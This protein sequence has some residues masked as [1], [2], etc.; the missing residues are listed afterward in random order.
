[1]ERGKMIIERIPIKDIKTRP[2]NVKIHTIE[3]IEKIKASIREFGNNDPVAVDE[4]NEL[5]EG[6]GRLLALSSLGYTEVEAIRLTHLTEAQKRA[7]SIIHNQLTLNSGFDYNVLDAELARI[8][9]IDMEQFGFKELSISPLDF[10]ETFTLASGDAPLVR[11]LSLTFTKE[12]MRIVTEA[13]K[14][15]TRVGSYKNWSDITN[16]QCNAVAEIFE[17]V[18]EANNL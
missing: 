14:R 1:M 7:Y 10:N 2:E 5:I 3:Q 17:Q 13:I 15:V 6:H 11:T 16:E 8:R 4:N 18:A 9:D 12:Q